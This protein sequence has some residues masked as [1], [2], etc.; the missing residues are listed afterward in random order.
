MTCGAHSWVSPSASEAVMANA[1][2]VHGPRKEGAVAW[3][4]AVSSK[5]SIG[6]GWVI[7]MRCQVPSRSQM[8]VWSFTYQG[9]AS[10]TDGS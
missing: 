10:P 1:C 8:N 5:G 6:S 3:H 2:F 7:P 9:C 4:R